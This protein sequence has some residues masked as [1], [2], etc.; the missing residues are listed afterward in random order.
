MFN[1]GEGESGTETSTCFVR[2]RFGL[3]R[4]HGGDCFHQHGFVGRTTGLL[5]E[6]DSVTARS[7]A[8]VAAITKPRTIAFPPVACSETAAVNAMCLF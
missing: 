7:A 8:G 1:K 5:S 3:I 2:V 6:S 4:L